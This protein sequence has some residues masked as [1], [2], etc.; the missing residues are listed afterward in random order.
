MFFFHACVVFN[1][2]SREYLMFPHV[3]ALLVKVLARFQPFEGV[4]FS[5]SSQN[6]RRNV[7]ARNGWKS[8]LVE[9]RS[10]R[11]E[12]KY[13]TRYV[14]SCLVYMLLLITFHHANFHAY[15][16]PRS[17]LSLRW[18]VREKENLSELC[19]IF[20]GNRKRTK[21]REPQRNGGGGGNRERYRN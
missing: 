2:T 19:T 18:E 16:L 17:S 8:S 21:S 13:E 12:Y 9:T 11:S 20:S 3:L 14:F 15:F 10:V 1:F 7:S 4:R 5:H 6:A